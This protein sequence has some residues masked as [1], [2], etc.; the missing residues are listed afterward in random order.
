VSR[1]RNGCDLL[2]S[3]ARDIPDLVILDEDIEG[4]SRE[5]IIQCLSGREELRDICLF[6]TISSGS[7]GTGPESTPDRCISLNWRDR[8]NTARALNSCL[9]RSTVHR[10]R[11]LP[12]RKERRWPRI[13]LDVTAR[14]EIMDPVFD[15][16]YDSGV[17]QIVDLSREGAGIAR[18]RLKKRHIPDG[19][20][21]IRLR[22][23]HPPLEN[24]KA[25]S[26]VTR[27][28]NSISA[29]LKFLDISRQDIGK[30]M[31]LFD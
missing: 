18:I 13:S 31:E 2:V 10:D 3:V 19:A 21:C 1:F 23:N 26:M 4:V 16:R 29:G 14:I 24:W 8:N 30:I 17:A 5:A 15:V 25:D 22:A 9:Y 27:M 11:R 6:R 12:P 28:D 7:S 20:F